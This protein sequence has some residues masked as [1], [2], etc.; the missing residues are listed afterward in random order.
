MTPVWAILACCII[1][2]SMYAYK[3]TV[4][5]AN[6][7]ILFV[8]IHLVIILLQRDQKH[9]MNPPEAFASHLAKKSATKKF[10]E[11]DLHG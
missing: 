5:R 7:Q 9:L 2:R 3:F 1:G 8:Q 11:K 10:A 6:R 4:L